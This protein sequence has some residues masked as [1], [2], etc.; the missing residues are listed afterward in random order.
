LQR[1]P[2]GLL[3]F[4]RDPV[5]LGVFWQDPTDCSSF[6]GEFLTGV[7]TFSKFSC[8]F[9]FHRF[10]YY[11]LQVVLTRGGA[12]K[13]MLFEVIFNFLVSSKLGLYNIYALA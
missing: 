4:Q 1:D 13:S 8:Y 10:F 2:I 7:E 6:Q 11:V 3:V 12:L 5:G 9:Y